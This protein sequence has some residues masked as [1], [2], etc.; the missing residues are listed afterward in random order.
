MELNDYQKQALATDSFLRQEAVV[1]VTEMAFL[2]KVLGLVGE[3]GEFAEK[4][5]KIIRN[6]DGIMSE[7]ERVE[8]LKELGDVLWYIASLSSYLGSDLE[9]VAQNNLDKLADR[10]KRDVI[11]SEGDN[12]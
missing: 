7:N 9:S 3:S 12:R 8:I 6:N 2:A 5:K 11:K 1:P 10:E 4:I